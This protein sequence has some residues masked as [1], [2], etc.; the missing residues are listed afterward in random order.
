MTAAAE[1][2][3]P[4]TEE[5]RTSVTDENPPNL[6]DNFDPDLDPG[7]TE[8][9]Q[10]LAGD[11]EDYLAADGSTV[12]SN[13]AFADGTGLK[14]WTSD[15]GQTYTTRDIRRDGRPVLQSTRTGLR[16]DEVNALV[17]ERG[18]SE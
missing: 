5:W 14:A 9:Q 6:T 8:P 1:A 4:P 13:F 12:V 7:Y 18:G 3:T 15:A 10:E 16:V 17:A 2:S 11:H